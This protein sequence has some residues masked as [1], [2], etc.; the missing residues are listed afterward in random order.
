MSGLSTFW[1]VHWWQAVGVF[2]ASGPAGVGSGPL[3]V[4][5]L[6]FVRSPALLVHIMLEYAFICDFKGVF[7]GFLLFRVGLYC[8]DALRG[9]WDFC[10]RE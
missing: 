3:V 1:R 4:C 9:L 6:P 5:S 8:L 10:V 7:S 2:D